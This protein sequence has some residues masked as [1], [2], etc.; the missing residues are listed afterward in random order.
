MSRSLIGRAVELEAVARFLAALGAGSAAALVLDGPPGSGKSALL[1][2]AAAAADAAGIQVL[3]CEGDEAGAPF[4]ALATLLREVEPAARA[5]LPAPQR[6][7]LE[8]ALAGG[9][10]TTAPIGAAFAG[11]AATGGAQPVEALRATQRAVATATATLLST[12]ARE[13]PLALLLDGAERLDR[14]SSL[15]LEFCARRLPPGAGL[16][17]TRLPHDDSERD[18]IALAALR[19]VDRAE[20]HLLGPLSPEELERLLRARLQRPGLFEPAPARAELSRV[21][22]AAGGN[23][24]HALALAAALPAGE[25]APA[26]LPPSA[27]PPPFAQRLQTLDAHAAAALLAIVTATRPTLPLLRRLLG[28][29]ATTEVERLEALELVAVVGERVLPAHPLLAGVVYAAADHEQRRTLHRRL[30]QAVDDPEERARQL[31]HAELLPQALPA[32]RA[33]AAGA[34]ARGAPATAAELLELALARHDD[35]LLRLRAAQHHFEAGDP[36]RAETLLLSAL[37]ELRR[38]PARA[39]A[40]LLLA[41]LRSHDDSHPRARALLEQARLEAGDDRRLHAAID[42]RLAVVLANRGLVVAA[43]APTVGARVVAEQLGDDALLAQALALETALA[44]ALGNGLDE[45][46][47]QRSLALEDADAPGGFEL[48]PSLLA[49]QL[50]LWSGRLGE[51]DALIERL[52]AGHRRRGE[53][54]ELA[55]AAFTRAAIAC[56]NG[57]LEAAAAVTEDAVAR[58]RA[59]GTVDARALALTASAQLA[60]RAG[61]ADD[62]CADAAAALELLEHSGWRTAAWRPLWTLGVVALSRGD[63][64][65]AAGWIAAPTLAALD[66]GLADPLPWSGAL[67]HGDAVE[68]LVGCERLTEA[69]RIATVLERR[70]AGSGRRWPRGVALRARGLLLAAAGELAEA[71]DC[72]QAAVEAHA[73]LPL[74]LERA[75]GL[76][77]LGRIQRRR[78]RAPARASLEAALALFEELGAP[79]WAAQ[80]R[81]ELERLG[82]VV[83]AP[84]QLTG[85]ERRVV[86]LVVTGM[87]NREVAT[88]LYLSPKTVETHLARVYRKLGIRS[89]AELGSRLAQAR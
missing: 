7:A 89:R 61:R 65:T 83:R 19:H 12:L 6:A 72:L 1:R 66:A 70:G 40:L 86:E 30:A 9:A 37:V 38:G 31:A 63:C 24:G 26:V 78:R 13:R 16:L 33:A 64:E 52:S 10:A 11:A 46:R 74:P 75:R 18:G 77:L 67:S 22:A 59:L 60:A 54:H 3:R 14:P 48:R 85:A 17:L 68:A 43:L 57:E 8:A 5:A 28:A 71:E 42:L 45:H 73:P 51:A 82:P 23:P 25:P 34:A 58:L 76:L 27:A 21:C 47:L 84:D 41:E 35:P 20:R 55:W 87:T 62:A 4:A 29:A 81:A 39:E 44:F 56:W 15:A 50:M 36:A 80:T 88:A 2:T 49:A 79:L 69:R 53:T 32:L